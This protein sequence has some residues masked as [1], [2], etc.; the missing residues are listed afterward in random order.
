MSWAFVLYFFGISVTVFLGILWWWLD[1]DRKEDKPENKDKG[2]D[3]VDST[4]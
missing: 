3:K 2:N 1:H 4:L